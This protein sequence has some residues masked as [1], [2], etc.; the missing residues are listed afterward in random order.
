M[1]EVIE[2]EVQH[3]R[4]AFPMAQTL[5]A[6]VPT[7]DLPTAVDIGWYDTSTHPEIG[8]FAVVGRESP[9]EDWIGEIILVSANGRACFVYV[10][11]SAD[12][13]TPLALARRAFAEIATL[14]TESIA[15]LVQVI[16]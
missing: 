5:L 12:V 15:A 16:G 10:I 9:H 4:R 6:G 2:P 7:G 11:A 13:P 8:S 14:S 1:T 3:A